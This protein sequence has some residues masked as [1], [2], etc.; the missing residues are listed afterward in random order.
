MGAFKKSALIPAA[1]LLPMVLVIGV[2]IWK[3]PLSIALANDDPVAAKVTNPQGENHPVA[4]T[5]MALLGFSG[6]NV[7]L[8]YQAKRAN[9]QA[10]LVTELV[11]EGAPQEKRQTM[12]AY[13]DASG[14]VSFMRNIAAYDYKK[15]PG[16][17]AV[18]TQEDGTEQIDYLT[19]G[20]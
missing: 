7:V 17:V 12:Y 8:T 18:L 15:K 16:L 6:T 3:G 19:L 13:A 14:K 10:R 1:C 11:Y 9:Y 5:K 2:Q 20:R 4:S